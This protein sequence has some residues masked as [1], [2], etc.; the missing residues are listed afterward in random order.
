MRAYFT[1][2]FATLP[3]CRAASLPPCSPHTP[4]PRLS[5]YSTENS[6]SL[7]DALRAVMAARREQD[8]FQLIVITHDEHFA[9]LIGERTPTRRG[10]GCNLT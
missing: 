10:C 5:A 8:N 4:N 2:P 3:Y 1:L 7:A 6:A 9:H